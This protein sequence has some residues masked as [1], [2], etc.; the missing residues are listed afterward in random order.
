MLLWTQWCMHLFELQFYLDIRPGVGLLVHM[1]TLLLVF[2]R[3]L[4]TVFHSGGTN[5][6]QSVG[7]FP[8][9]QLKGILASLV[10][11]RIPF[12]GTLVKWSPG[13]GRA[14]FL[15]KLLGQWC[16]LIHKSQSLSSSIRTFSLTAPSH[17]AAFLCLLPLLSL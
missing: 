8:F 1:A 9:L 2:W 16:W 11:T 4:Q 15:V 12:S 3:K 14:L 7:G 17:L 5:S 13:K 6:H 10:L